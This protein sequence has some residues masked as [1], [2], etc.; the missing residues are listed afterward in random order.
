M[1]VSVAYVVI[2][3]ITDVMICTFSHSEQNGTSHCDSITYNLGKSGEVLKSACFITRTFEMYIFLFS[4]RFG[5]FA[6]VSCL[7]K[8]D[9]A[10]HLE[11]MVKQMIESLNSSEG[12]T[13]S[14]GLLNK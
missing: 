1:Y 7:L 10:P 3:C 12:I 13:V 2:G 11:G 14:L 5:L 8:E 9:M 4:Y 6:A